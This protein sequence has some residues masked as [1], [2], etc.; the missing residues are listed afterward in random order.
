M[1]TIQNCLDYYWDGNI[2]MNI[3]KM[4][5]NL[6]I[7][8]RDNI[9]E[10][11]DYFSSIHYESEKVILS[12]KK[13]ESQERQRFAIA[14]ALCN[15]L[16][17]LC[18]SKKDIYIYGVEN[19]REKS[20]YFSEQIN[21]AVIDLIIPNRYLKFVINKYNLTKLETLSTFFGVSQ[22]A[23]AYQIKKTFRI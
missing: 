11:A 9:P 4:S 15:Y 7:I 10:H 3:V 23:M 14:H 2:P 16:A 17:G 5:H 6:G 12:F 19:F 8:V 13:T 20:D 1:K 18:Y 21:K 22:S